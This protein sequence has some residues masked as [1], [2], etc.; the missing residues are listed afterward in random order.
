MTFWMSTA[1]RL[2]AKLLA[3]SQVMTVMGKRQECEKTLWQR[4]PDSVREVLDL[5]C[6]R[7]CFNQDD[8]M[9]QYCKIQYA[10][11]VQYM[12]IL[13]VNIPYRIQ[14]RYTYIVQ[15]MVY[16]GKYSIHGASGYHESN[17]F[18]VL[19]SD[20]RTKQSQDVPVPA[21]SSDTV[22]SKMMPGASWR[23]SKQSRGHWPPR[24]TV[25]PF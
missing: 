24:F 20:Q 17:S 15:F 12:L 3:G 8:D 25:R 13:V 21:T 1:G 2:V 9:A 10:M 5:P 22:A 7:T 18:P 19:T 23:L 6:I 4:F 11:Q 14:D 16:I